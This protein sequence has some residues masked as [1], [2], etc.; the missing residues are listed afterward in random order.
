MNIILFRTTTSTNP[1]KWNQD[2]WIS[3]LSRQ[4]PL[5]VKEFRVTIESLQILVSCL[6]LHYEAI[7]HHILLPHQRTIL[8]GLPQPASIHG[9]MKGNLLTYEYLQTLD[10]THHQ[11][12]ALLDR[13]WDIQ[14]AGSCMPHTSMATTRKSNA[15]HHHVAKQFF[16]FTKI[17]T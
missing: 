9:W 13:V 1:T 17:F 2:S 14:L 10:P 15:C 6:Q 8:K 4:S 7:E 3:S 5:L 12:T 11:P 16:I